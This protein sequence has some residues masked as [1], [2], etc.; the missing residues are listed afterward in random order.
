MAKTKIRPAAK[1]P[2]WPQAVKLF[3]ASL[4]E[5]RRSVLTV[6]N[7]ATDIA[8]FAAWL[9]EE[10]GEEPDLTQLTS[11]DLLEWQ[12]HIEALPGRNGQPAALQT[13]NRKVAAMR[14]FLR[15]A[16]DEER[17]WVAAQIKPPRPRKKQAAEQPHWLTPAQQRALEAAVELRGNPRDTVMVVLGIH[18]GLRISEM[19]AL[20]WPD[21]TIRERSGSLIVRHGKGNKQR[22]VPLNQTA[23][24]ALAALKATAPYNPAAGDSQAI[25]IGQ[26]GPLGV[27]GVWETLT[28]YAKTAKIGKQVGIEGFT[29]HALRHT[30]GRRLI[31]AGVPLPEVSQL[32]GHSDPK[33][34]MGYLTASAEGQQRAVDRL[35]GHG[36][37]TPA[38]P[39]PA[40][41]NPLAEHEARKRQYATVARRAGMRIL[42]SSDKGGR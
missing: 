42:T 20:E 2:A 18:A 5:E 38:P 13:V 29:P 27:K 35:D 34:T 9:Q 6:R 40:R 1:A 11:R 3:V 7:Y 30:F 19:V 4:Q 31:E 41:Y 16:Q 25:L 37:P 24:E 33:T 23:R 39:R 17:G 22:T 15:W 12:Q 10:H 28:G 26:R 36:E 32:M 8:G 21:I 14:A